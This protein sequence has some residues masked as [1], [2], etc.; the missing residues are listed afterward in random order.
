MRN[1]VLSL[2]FGLGVAALGLG[3]ILWVVARYDVGLR[4][5]QVSPTLTVPGFIAIAIGLWLTLRTI[6]LV[7]LR[8]TL[9]RGEG[10]LA[11]WW[12]TPSE[13]EA[14]R[15]HDAIR[16]AS[17]STLR[18]KLAPA[19][20]PA[21]MAAVPVAIGATAIAVGRS[22]VPLNVTGWGPFAIW[23]LCDVSLAD[24]P[25]PS[26][27]F[28]RYIVSRNAITES[29]DLVRIPLGAGGRA[30]AQRIVDHFAAAIPSFHKESGRTMFPDHFLAV[31]GDPAAAAR[32]RRAARGYV[33]PAAVLGFGG[34]GFWYSM[35]GGIRPMGLDFATLVLV[36]AIAALA[37]SAIFGLAHFARRHR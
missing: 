16:S 23:A 11:R 5:G 20:G 22:I 26:L 28:S 13:W 25:S 21:P 31:A 34:L 33:F 10:A 12:V 18:N 36:A 3:Y 37:L 32:E 2:L 29:I 35:T 6:L 19:A 8:D 15:A 7:R 27:E 1:P 30:Q 14:W 24:G 4:L 17:W 9:L